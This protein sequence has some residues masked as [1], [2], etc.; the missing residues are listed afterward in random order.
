MV[1][2]VEGPLGKHVGMS[3]DNNSYKLLTSGDAWNLY[4]TISSNGQNIAYANGTGPNDL[5]IV[6][7]NLQSREL[8]ILTEP[9][10]VLQPMF[11][12]NGKR[13]FFSHQVAGIN[14]IAYIDLNKSSDIKYITEEDN[15]FF[16]APF[17][18]GEMLVYQRNIKGQEREIV[19]F[20]LV[21]N[22]KE[23]IGLGMSPALSKDE[24][25]I[26]YTSKVNN[27]WDVYIYDRFAKTTKRVTTDLGHDFSPTFDR[28][29][30][31]V[32]TSDRLENGVF[33][34]FTQTKGSWNSDE[35]NEKIL[36]TKKG[37]SFYAPRIAGMEQYQTIQMPQMIG[38]PRSSFGTINH[39]GNIYAVGGHQ[40]AEHTYPPESFTGRMT[41][42]NLATKTW[43]NLAA[44]PHA[45]HGYQLAAQGKYIYA[46]GG[47]AFEET[48][49]P[50]WK[51]LDVV[52]RYNIETDKW[53]EL[54]PMP[55]RR[56]SNVVVKVGLK[57]Y[58]LGGWDATPKFDDDIDGTFHDEIDVFDLSTHR[59]SVLKT[60]LPKKRRAFSGFEKDGKIYLVG[61]IS[62]GG[63]HF[64]LNDEFTKFDPVTETF[65][66]MP[67]LPFGTFAPAAG[68]MG[69][70]AYMFGGMF[71]TG[72]F[73]YEYVPHIYQFDF[74]SMKW[75]HTGRF[76]NEYKGFSQVVPIGACLGILG[77]HSYKD[78]RDKPV[79]TFENFCSN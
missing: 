21:E 68:S 8:K 48:T 25:Y 31:L 42:Y 5:V 7:K 46:F 73:N 56:S 64:S 55:R 38:E 12:Q 70:K 40:G 60:K 62:E 13:L 6:V 14:K 39:N 77:G 67:K 24:H 59:W 35:I 15:S 49:S 69:E 50:K 3:E 1:F 72:K 16:P 66:D 71:K 54:G 47:F 57:V 22:T 36:I 32:Y 41:A 53:E 11:S 45:A 76:L 9:G 4:P 78:G 75:T 19:L 58:L 63:S 28:L 29:G 61:G 74:N 26:A 52:E 20:D 2:L 18:S 30:N 10:F 44:R 37:T 23:V 51:S 17:Q 33:S 65:K 43:K 34:I 27:N 79:D